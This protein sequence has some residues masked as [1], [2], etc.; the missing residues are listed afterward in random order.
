[1]TRHTW[2]S[3]DREDYDQLCHEAWQHSDS[4]RQRT[5]EFLR[6]LHDAGQAHRLFAH[7]MLREA[8]F[9]GASSILK[10]WH[11]RTHRVAVAYNGE[12]LTKSRAV[13][14]VKVAADGL[15]YATQ[16]LFDMLTFEQLQA[17][18]VEYRRQVAAYRENIHICERLLSLRDLA[19]E[20]ATPAEACQRLGTTVDDFLAE[21]A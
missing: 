16:T 12:L 17:K 6:L 5:E 8:E 7:D 4:T 13:G 3:E 20:A 14:T 1:M 10:E 21:A 2:P 9:R 19:P 11:K 18:I 15:S